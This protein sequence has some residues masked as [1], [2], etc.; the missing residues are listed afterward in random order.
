VIATDHAPHHFDDKNKEFNTAAF[1]ISGLETAFA[2]GIQL[3]K[4]G[5]LSLKQLITKMS[6]TPSK[7]MKIKK[8]ALAVNAD[9]DIA[10][11][12]LNKKFVVDSSKFLSKGKN[13]P[14]DGFHLKGTVEK[15]ISLGKIHEW[16]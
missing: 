12:N 14:F 9:A 4:Q 7:I 3:V 13:T 15:T 1:G 16:T 2:L 5:V 8:G 11:I 6:L 10:I